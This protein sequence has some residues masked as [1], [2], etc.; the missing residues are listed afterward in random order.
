MMRPGT[1]GD[2]MSSNAAV[3]TGQAPLRQLSYALLLDV[4]ARIL[5]LAGLLGTMVNLLAAGTRLPPRA[6]LVA[7]LCGSALMLV[8]ESRIFTLREQL[9]LRLHGRRLWHVTASE[10]RAALRGAGLQRLE[11][12]HRTGTI[13]SWVAAGAVIIL[14]MIGFLSL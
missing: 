14:G 5:F 10:E 4:M 11:L 8:T 13:T 9:G 12:T 2:Q 3:Q 7:V 1:D 6:L